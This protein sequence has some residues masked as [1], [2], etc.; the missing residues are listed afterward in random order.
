MP[1]SKYTKIKCD[2]ILNELKALGTERN[3]EGMKRYGINTDTA[4]GVSMPVIRGKAKEI[5][6][7][8][9]LAVM[10]W[11]TG[12][13]DLRIL[14]ALID[15]PEK[16]TEKQLEK[17]VAGFDS[18]DVCDQVC[19]NLFDKTPFAFGKAVEWAE[20][21][22]EFV[23]RAGFV[24][25]ASLAVHD[26]KAQDAEF[27][28]FLPIVEKSADDDRN[29]VRKAVNWALRQIGKRN[30]GL[31]RLAVATAKRIKKSGSKSA[32][33]VASDAI[34]ELTAEKTLSRLKRKQSCTGR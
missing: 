16:V 23:K 28:G 1:K 9:D 29:F 12:M 7:D 17:W 11:D 22:E 34:R 13:H 33:W 24:L 32:C 31:N 30:A 14:A 4:F 6:R 25:M 20:R 27:I 8:H 3:R 15:E 19:M 10:L 2:E 5:G 18:W 26:K 21:E